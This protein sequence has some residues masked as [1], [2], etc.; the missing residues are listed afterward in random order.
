M[1][2]PGLAL[3]RGAAST[4][5]SPRVTHERSHIAN[6][7][8]NETPYSP[9]AGNSSESK[10]RLIALRQSTPKEAYF[11]SSLFHAE[12]GI[13]QTAIAQKGIFQTAIA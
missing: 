7:D 12:K 9:G 8:I 3:S 10:S 5:P 2:G 11:K 1:Q 4:A 6:L 13:F